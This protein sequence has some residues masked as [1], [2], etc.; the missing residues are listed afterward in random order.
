MAM[1][2]V[3]PRMTGPVGIALAG[4][5]WKDRKIGSYGGWHSAIHIL[6]RTGN[7]LS[8][9]KTHSFPPADALTVLELGKHPRQRAM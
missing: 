8:P 1:A 3:E 9:I 6:E 7:D 2:N 4:I 5:G